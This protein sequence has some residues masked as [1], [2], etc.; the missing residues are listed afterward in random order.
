MTN[1]KQTDQTPTLDWFIISIYSQFCGCQRCKWN[2]NQLKNWKTVSIKMLLLSCGKSI[3]IIQKWKYFWN[4][5]QN[6]ERKTISNP[7]FTFVNVVNLLE[8]GSKLKQRQSKSSNG[9]D[10]KKK[11]FQVNWFVSQNREPNWHINLSNNNWWIS[12]LKSEAIAKQKHNW[13]NDDQKNDNVNCFVQ[14]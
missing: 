2:L 13:S 1:C 9:T 6:F 7:E 10:S 12:R 14:E 8:T 3:H 4:N 5:G 11:P